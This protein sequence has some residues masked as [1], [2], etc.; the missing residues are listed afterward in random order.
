MSSASSISDGHGSQG[1][2]LAGS[3]GC[4]PR[5]GPEDEV[6]ITACEAQATRIEMEKQVWVCERAAELLGT[7]PE[8]GLAGV[9]AQATDEWDMYRAPRSR[10]GGAKKLRTISNS[11]K[12]CIGE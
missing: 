2:R 7:H 12:H 10:G 6:M 3:D 9:V 5:I 4:I 1:K 8:L 11:H